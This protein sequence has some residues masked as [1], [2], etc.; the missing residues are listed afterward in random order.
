MIAVGQ[1][2]GAVRLAPLPQRREHQQ[3]RHP[4]SEQEGDQTPD[5]GRQQE[6][7]DDRV[8]VGKLLHPLDWPDACLCGLLQCERHVQ[9]AFLPAVAST[10]NPGGNQ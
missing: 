1:P 8:V 10:P 4:D 9:S 7:A 6:F 3:Q 2:H 5:I